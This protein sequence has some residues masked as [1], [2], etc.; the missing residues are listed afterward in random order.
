[1]EEAER[2]AREEHGSIKLVVISGAHYAS[3][4]LGP[5]LHDVG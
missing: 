5:G 3:C 1:M 2:V 4:S